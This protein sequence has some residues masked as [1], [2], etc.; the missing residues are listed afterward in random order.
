MCLAR[1]VRVSGSLWQQ[2]RRA[3]AR[4]TE[5]QRKHCEFEYNRKL[6][7]ANTEHNVICEHMIAQSV[8]FVSR[9]VCTFA[10]KMCSC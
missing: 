3:R 4:V 6:Y 5:T 9:S 2:K 10:T 1:E 8:W 7:K